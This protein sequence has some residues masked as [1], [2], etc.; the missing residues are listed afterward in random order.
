MKNYLFTLVFVFVAL[1]SNAQLY[2]R[3]TYY[4][5][6]DD[7]IKTEERK[8]LIH[9]TDTTFV[10]E[11][12]GKEPVVYFIINPGHEETVGTKDEPVNLINNVY[13]YEK[14]W[15]VIRYDKLGEVRDAFSK[16]IA[17]ESE[18][19]KNKLKSKI[20][21][22]FLFATHRTITTQFT[23]EY[24]DEMFWIADDRSDG[25]LGKDVN[26]IIYHKN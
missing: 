8:T 19:N 21:S 16:I 18:S 3:V 11:E 26:R 10:I 12:K 14:T 17:E 25:K 23:K 15:G 2:E 7:V 22:Y 24:L 4:D 13:G 20:T 5:K 6:F 1:S 9:K